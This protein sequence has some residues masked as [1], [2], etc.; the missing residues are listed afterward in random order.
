MANIFEPEWVERDQ[1]PLIGR[2]A[3]VG[4]QAGAERLGATLY[5][6]DPAGY[7]S[8]FHLHHGN[9]EMIIVLAGRPSL[10][11]LEGIRELEP[12]DVVACPVGR[13]GAHPLQNNSDEPVRALVIS[14]MTIP[15][16]PSSSTATRFS[17]TPP[18]RAPP[19]GSRSPSHAGHR[20]TG[21]PASCG[22]QT[23]L[24]AERPQRHASTCRSL[25][26]APPAF[27]RAV[28]RQARAI[29]IPIVCCA[30][31]AISDP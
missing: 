11:T 8:P 26:P 13:R 18:R 30:S 16:S 22:S 21:S 4:A 25:G 14:T 15:R 23:A 31:P 1:A 5:E 6:I 27:A 19:T 28:L 20:S 29:A 9:E 12:G 3:R 10:R 17:S 7:G 2:A 24:Q